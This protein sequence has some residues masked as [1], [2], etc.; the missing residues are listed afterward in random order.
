MTGFIANV[1]LG[2]YRTLEWVTRFK[3]PIM[4][5]ENG[6]EDA[7]DA[8]RPRYLVEHIH[9]V[10]RGINYNWPIKGYFQWSLVDNFEWERGW[11]QRFGLWG[12]DLETQRRIRRTSV[13]LYADICRTNA[14]SYDLIAKYTPELLPK[15]FPG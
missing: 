2:L 4:I 5:T 12:L 7:D 3:L 9:Q 1:P 11:T 13:D 15:M 6:V 8:M 10:W 14:I